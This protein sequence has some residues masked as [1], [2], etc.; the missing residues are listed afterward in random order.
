M[1]S[2]ILSS[3]S[4]KAQLEKEIAQLVQDNPTPK[5]LGSP[6]NSELRSKL[7]S[8]AAQRKVLAEK[9]KRRDLILE[10]ERIQEVLREL[11]E[12]HPQ[13]SMFFM[14]IIIYACYLKLTNIYLPS[15][16]KTKYEC[17]LCLEEMTE[18][19]RCMLVCCGQ[20]TC[21]TC[22]AENKTRDQ[23]IKIKCCPLCRHPQFGGSGKERYNNV[24][25]FAER[26]EAWAQTMM[27]DI[28][29]NLDKHIVQKKV[30]KV[31]AR[32]WYSLAEKQEF[33]EAIYKCA[34]LDDEDGMNRSLYYEKL[35]KAALLGEKRSA[36]TLAIRCWMDSKGDD[37]DCLKKVEYY[38]S[39]ALG[40]TSNA[41]QQEYLSTIFGVALSS[42]THITDKVSFRKAAV[43]LYRTKYYLDMGAKKNF[44]CLPA[45]G[46]PK[47]RQVIIN[48]YAN[49]ILQLGIYEYDGYAYEIPGYSF[50]PKM[51]Y[52]ANEAGGE[53]TFLNKVSGPDDYGRGG[54]HETHCAYCN[55]EAPRGTKFKQCVKCKAAWCK[56]LRAFVLTVCT[57][58]AC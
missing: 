53:K 37:K 40:S 20:G 1:A 41:S 14:S 33:A 4:E 55:I 45:A 19:N 52:W 3:L 38:A 48:I 10:E 27:G 5:F 31:K 28:Y 46:G 6:I 54:R 21:K 17:A 30:N 34:D 35:E 16:S 44:N 49:T 15:L 36:Q 7:Q 24:L 47:L 13:V 11:G 39:I 23:S 2:S 42:F 50:L 8:W 18:T 22:A 26:G 32:K 56:S 9:R 43:D 12:L 29:M 58:F 51:R 25:K 57:M